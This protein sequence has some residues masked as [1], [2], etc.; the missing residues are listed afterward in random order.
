MPLK[1][2]GLKQKQ[3]FLQKVYER[4]QSYVPAKDF[5]VFVLKFQLVLKY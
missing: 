2:E 5:L 3:S 1:A 4:V